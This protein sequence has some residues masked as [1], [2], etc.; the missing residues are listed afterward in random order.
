MVSAQINLIYWT[1]SFLLIF[2][3]FNI[4]GVGNTTSVA[5]GGETKGVNLGAIHC[6]QTI[7]AIWK[8]NTI[9]K[10][11]KPI[12]CYVSMA[13][14]PESSIN[15]KDWF[16]WHTHGWHFR[17]IIIAWILWTWVNMIVKRHV[18]NQY[19]FFAIISIKTQ[20]VYFDIK[21]LLIIY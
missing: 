21:Y 15:Y 2:I 3:T 6:I 16:V 17:I 19:G 20:H 18:P 13:T 14:D 8:W 9:C 10:P 11:S 12:S 1:F 7:I 5:L 4:W